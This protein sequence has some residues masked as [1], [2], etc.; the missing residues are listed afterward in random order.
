MPDGNRSPN[1]RLDYQAGKGIPSILHKPTNLRTAN[2]LRGQRVAMTW[3]GYSRSS[4]RRRRCGCCAPRAVHRY[5]STSS[6]SGL[7]YHRPLPTPGVACRYL[8]LKSPDAPGIS[9]TYRRLV[10]R[11]HRWLPGSEAGRGELVYQLTTHRG[12]SSF[13]DRPRPVTSVSP[14][15]SRLRLVIETSIYLVVVR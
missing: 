12:R 1:R 6:S 8:T 10:L 4:R 3:R 2:T 14:T 15:E 9:Q 13:L 5:L 7:P 11:R